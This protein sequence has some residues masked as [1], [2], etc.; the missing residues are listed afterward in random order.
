MFWLSFCFYFHCW[1]F[2]RKL[3][4]ICIE[5]LLLFSA[6]RRTKFSDPRGFELITWGWFVTLSLWSKNHTTRLRRI[7]AGNEKKTIHIN[8]SITGVK[9]MWSQN[10][11]LTLTFRK[12]NWPNNYKLI[13]LQAR[14]KHH[15]NLVLTFTKQNWPT[16]HKQYNSV[17][18]GKGNESSEQAGFRMLHF[19]ASQCPFHR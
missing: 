16:N 12:Q 2:Y 14:V 18:R 7:C 13:R 6:L 9:S 3:L 15:N 17:K 10:N 4:T 19:K 5:S 8:C 11:S 1:F